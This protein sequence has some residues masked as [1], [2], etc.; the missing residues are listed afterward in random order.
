MSDEWEW[1][2]STEAGSQVGSVLL[3]AGFELYAVSGGRLFG[4]A[5]DEL[6]VPRV[7]VYRLE[8]E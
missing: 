5:T 8:G 3:P 2:A 7:Q 4:V 1:T 6:D